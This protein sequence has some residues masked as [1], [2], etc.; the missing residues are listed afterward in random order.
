MLGVL[1]LTLLTVLVLPKSATVEALWE[2]GRCVR[3]LADL[4]AAA[5]AAAP[6]QTAA[7]APAAAAAPVAPGGAAVS[8][9]GGGDVEAAAASPWQPA[10]GGAAASGS[11]ADE[12]SAAAADL[13]AREDAYEAG[14]LEIYQSVLKLRDLLDCSRNELFVFHCWGRPL[15]LPLFGGN[16]LRAC[17]GRA[18]ARCGGGGGSGGM[19]P[20]EALED[21]TASC[22]RLAR[23]LGT[24]HLGHGDAVRGAGLA[25]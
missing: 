7:A 4:N 19:P 9:S 6:P 1:L 16:A 21:L 12:G 5:A 24:L 2:A 8:A 13:E 23:L 22:R 20:R 14:L 18:A 17:L 10:A 11:G 25:V 15:V 3:L